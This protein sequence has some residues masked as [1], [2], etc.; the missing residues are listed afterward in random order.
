M[1]T[2]LGMH[3]FCSECTIFILKHIFSS[4]GQQEVYIVGLGY[5]VNILGSTLVHLLP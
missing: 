2:P 1:F 3:A 5:I 4:F